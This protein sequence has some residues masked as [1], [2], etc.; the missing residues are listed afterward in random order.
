MSHGFVCKYDE[1]LS[2]SETIKWC[3]NAFKPVKN[4]TQETLKKKLSWVKN[5][6]Q[7]VTA[8]TSNATTIVL[9]R[10]MGKLPYVSPVRILAKSDLEYLTHTAE[11]SH[12]SI[13]EIDTRQ[14]LTI[15]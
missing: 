2:L 1:F 7:G 13:E 6:G 5:S 8:L 3:E 15:P 4:Y 12:D 9:K 10:L 11:I 14:N